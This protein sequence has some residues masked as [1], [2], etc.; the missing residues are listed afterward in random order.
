MSTIWVL[1]QAMV[2]GYRTRGIYARN[3]ALL[4]LL[5][6]STEAGCFAGS[7]D[8]P[9]CLTDLKPAVHAHIEFMLSNL[10]ASTSNSDSK[11]L[12]S[13]LGAI[14]R[15]QHTR[16]L[17]PNSEAFCRCLGHQLR[18]KSEEGRRAVM[19]EA[20]NHLWQHSVGCGCPFDPE[21]REVAIVTPAKY[22]FP[23]AVPFFDLRS[24]FLDFPSDPPT[25]SILGLVVV[26]FAKIFVDASWLGYSENME[27]DHLQ[28]LG[29]WHEAA[30]D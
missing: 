3:G 14:E 23:F 12:R 26:W 8:H 24:P 6:H 5:L 4:S 13:H 9:A 15:S 30:R 21:S 17:F 2:L 11:N 7:K 22:E 18:A 10:R 27:D 19:A 29:Q 25:I 16:T 28:Y 1:H 20:E